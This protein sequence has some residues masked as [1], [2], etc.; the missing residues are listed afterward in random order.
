MASS[1]VPATFDDS[2]ASVDGCSFACAAKFWLLS[3]G[4]SL[5]FATLF[6]KLWRLNRL[7]HNATRFRH[8]QV[9]PQ[10][11]M[12]PCVSLMGINVVVLTIWSVVFPPEWQRVIL[13]YDNY[14]RAN[15]SSGKCAYGNKGIIFIGVILAINGCALVMALVQAYHARVFTT[16]LR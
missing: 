16:K 4:F 15:E 14:G 13:D 11:V 6:S 3:I 9:R 5:S 8:V 12:V 7:M 10:D 2:I 1:I